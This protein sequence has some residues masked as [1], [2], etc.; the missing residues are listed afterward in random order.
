M[1]TQFSFA[2]AKHSLPSAVPWS[3]TFMILDSTKL[4]CFMDCPRKFFYEYLLG[5]RPTSPNNHLVFG[6]AIHEAMEYLYQNGFEYP[7]VLAAHDLFMKCYRADFPDPTSDEMYAPKT[8]ENA[9]VALEEYTAHYHDD[10]RRYKTVFTEIAG[11][12][13]VSPDRVLNFKMDTILEDTLDETHCCLEHKTKGGGFNRMWN[14]QWLLSI[15]TGTYAHVLNSLYPGEERML[16]NVNGIAFLKTKIDFNRVPV[17]YGPDQMR[18]W[19]WNVNHLYDLYEHYMHL[20]LD[21]KE[22]DPVL[23]TFPMCTESCTK[24]FGC[25]YQDFCYSWPNPLRRCYE[26]PLGFQIF[27]WDPSEIDATQKVE[28]R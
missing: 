9:L 20:L 15:Q 25:V 21:S 14:D 3:P 18:V 5:W 26:P 28:L 12:V 1:T 8:P 24:Y 10:P 11:T 4:K 13:P 22:S 17:E 16:V 2:G 19:L 27:H 23:R 6:A 7:K